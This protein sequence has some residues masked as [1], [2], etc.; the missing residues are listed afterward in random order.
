M[1]ESTFMIFKPDSI[2]GNHVQ[3]ILERIFNAGLE[4][5][6]FKAVI[7]TPELI[8]QHYAHIADKPFFK[9]IEDFMVKGPLYI[10][11]LTGDDAVNTWRGLMGATNPE[12]AEQGTIRGDFGYV[13]NGQVFNM[14]HGSDSIDNAKRE[15][16]LWF[17]KDVTID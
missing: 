9:A 16:E 12:V 5:S 17:G 13:K 1:K 7:A 4:I 10:A 14:V 3:Q 8:E 11:I 6:H 2:E 15:I